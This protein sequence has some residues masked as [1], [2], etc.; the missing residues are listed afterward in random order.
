MAGEQRNATP[1]APSGGIDSKALGEAIAAATSAAVAE[2]M[3]PIGEALA[4][5][6]PP[7]QPAT[8]ATTSTTDKPKPLTLDDL[9]RVLNDRDKQSR[10][11][12]DLASRRQTYVA[13]KLKDLPPFAAAQ[14]GNDPAKWP[15]E[16]QAARTQYR[17]FMKSQGVTLPDVSGNPPASK[18][19]GGTTT[20]A[21][22]PVDLSKMSPV[23]LIEMG[24]KNDG[25]APTVGAAATRTQPAAV[26]AGAATA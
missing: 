9:T 4:K 1:P 13:D 25:P 23:Q 16:E 14:L 19:A 8:T 12:A 2:A 3:K 7:A 21:G 24:L 10:E 6:Q 26:A 15:A 11:S 17:E 5:L 20:P 22:A 18:A